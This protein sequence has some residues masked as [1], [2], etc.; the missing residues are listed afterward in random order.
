MRDLVILFIHLL[1][2]IAK[3]MLSGG[4]RTVVAESL[5]LKHQLVVLNRGRERAPNLRPMDRG[6]GETKKPITFLAKTTR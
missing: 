6:N 1:T 5:L 3:I 2:T 4:G